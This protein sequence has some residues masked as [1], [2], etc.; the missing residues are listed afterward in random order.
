MSLII[1]LQAQDRL[2]ARTFKGLSLPL[3]EARVFQRPTFREC[4][5]LLSPPEKALHTHMHTHTTATVCPQNGSCHGKPNKGNAVFL[6]FS[7]HISVGKW[8]ISKCIQAYTS[9]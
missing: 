1:N 7:A 4:A 2:G 6:E 9:A 3:G 5:S 8:K